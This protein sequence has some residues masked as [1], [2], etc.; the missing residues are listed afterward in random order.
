MT[1]STTKKTR[2]ALSAHSWIGVFFGAFLYLICIS[3][4]LS[5]FYQEWERWEQP[6]IPEFSETSPERVQQV[7]DTFRQRYD[8]ETEHYHVVLPTSG[9]PRLVVEDDHVAHFVSEEGELLEIEKPTFTTLLTHLHEFLH[10]PTN[11]GVVIVSLFGA[12]ICGLIVSGIVAH[13]RIIK[14]A[15][16]FRRGGS[17]LQQNIDLH[18]RIGVWASPFHLIIGVTGTYFGLAGIVLVI[19]AQ[20]FYGGDREAVIGEVFTAEPELSL[21]IQPV[22]VGKALAKTLELEPEGK[23]IFLTVHEPNSE[24][25]FI[26]V[27][28]KIQGKLIYS[29]NYRFKPDGTYIGSAGYKEGELGKQAIY[30]LYRLHFGD[31]AGLPM[32]LVYFVLG[33]MLTLL[34]TSGINIWLLKQNRTETRLARVWHGIV[35]GTPIALSISAILVFTRQYEGVA[36]FWVPLLLVVALAAGLTS[37]NKR[38]LQQLTA[39][40]LLSALL[41]YGMTHQSGV[42]AIP[43]LLLNVPILLYAVYLLYRSRVDTPYLFDRNLEAAK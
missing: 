16:R 27:Y 41:V 40:S 11:I 18:N 34:A 3:G 1:T 29:E 7:F 24:G 42:F 15:F 31:F 17:G 10:L 35:W 21:P 25:Q 33:M 36:I 9:I 2:N 19:V 23:P 20:A 30:S 37:M 14:D 6:N 38:R 12:M 43:S 26:E 13:K 8:T 32:K 5:V 22:E 4:A 39:F 28:T